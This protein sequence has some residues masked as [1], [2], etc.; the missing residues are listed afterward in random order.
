MQRGR[1]QL[2]V[3]FVCT[4]AILIGAA[5]G[6]DVAR[7]S[8]SPIAVSLGSP[9]ASQQLLVTSTSGRRQ[10]DVTRNVRYES[11]ES[12]IAVVTRD[13]RVLPR[14][15]GATEILVHGKAATARMLSVAVPAKIRLMAKA[16]TTPSMPVSGRIRHK[17]EEAAT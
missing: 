7:L 8:V 10:V 16:V 4:Q 14:G 11:A 3:A 12:K 1:A 6:S 9:E 17:E 5:S 2:A 15:E 13:G